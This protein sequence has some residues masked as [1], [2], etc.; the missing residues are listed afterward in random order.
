MESAINPQILKSILE[1]SNN[2]YATNFYESFS[3]VIQFNEKL[4]VYYFDKF[5]IPSYKKIILQNLNYPLTDDVYE[6]ISTLTDIIGSGLHLENRCKTRDL[7]KFNI[8]KSA[9]R[10]TNDMSTEILL[11][12]QGVSI[13]TF[14]LIMCE[15][16]P[17]CVSSYGREIYINFTKA[18]L[19]KEDE[20]R[21]FTNLL[22]LNSEEKLLSKIKL[23]ISN[24]NLKE[25]NLE[26]CL[27]DI[28]NYF[29]LK[30]I[31]P[32]PKLKFFTDFF[33]L[34]LLLLHNKLLQRLPIHS[35]LTFR[36]APTVSLLTI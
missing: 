12:L 20:V 9:Y 17:K 23:Y 32:R 11:K 5:L 33:R 14:K 3:E 16:M 18:D 35:I 28:S 26:I 21:K 13:S 30:R 8:F 6:K 34:E 22:I 10:Y 27:L 1:K 25:N 24:L 29:N 36:R 15:L 2:S 31:L 4:D 19:T 7:L